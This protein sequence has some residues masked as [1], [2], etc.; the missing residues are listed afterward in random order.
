[1]EEKS[2]EIEVL[3]ETLENVMVDHGQINDA[4]HNQISA[5][6]RQ[7]AAV[8]EPAPPARQSVSFACNVSETELNKMKADVSEPFIT[9]Y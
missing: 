8:K 3:T 4:L 2:Q 6:Q 7:L 1:M 9:S 5:L